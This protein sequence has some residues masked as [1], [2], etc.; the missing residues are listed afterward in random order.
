MQGSGKVVA[1]VLAGGDP[2]DAL[3]RAANVPSKALVP[4]DGRPMAAYVLAALRAS[5]S[6][7][8]LLLVGPVAD[9][10]DFEGVHVIPGGD[11]FGHSLAL[12]LGAAQ[13]LSPG[14]SMLVVTADV[15]W[16]TP[17][18]IDLFVEGAGAADLAYPI[19]SEEAATAAFPSHERTFVRLKQGRFTGGNLMLLKPMMIA[20]LLR[21]MDRVYLARKNPLALARLVGPRT[22]LALLAGRADLRRLEQIVS[23][24]LGGVARAVVSQDA[25]LAADVDGVEHLNVPMNGRVPRS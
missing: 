3:A 24:R 12:G 10:P 25:S 13:A 7:G 16:L 20:P 11:A 8:E 2:D 14:A 22:L 4:L 17:R 18:G 21:F 6:V 23:A 5:C 19:V 9:E 1:V 15:P